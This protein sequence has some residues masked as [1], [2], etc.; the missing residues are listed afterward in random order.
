M[1]NQGTK[2]MKKYIPYI[3]IALIIFFMGRYSKDD[4][5]PELKAKWQ[6][7]RATLLDGITHKDARILAL[8][9]DSATIRKKMRI[10]SLE[11]A[12]ALNA[13]K[14]ATLYYKKLYEKINLRNASVAQL[15][16]I[17]ASLRASS[18]HPPR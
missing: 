16:S 2:I 8:S 3:A 4:T 11:S 1:I 17:R 9:A 15:D 10:D 6:E 12:R 7:E 18:L 5:S 14:A 13:E